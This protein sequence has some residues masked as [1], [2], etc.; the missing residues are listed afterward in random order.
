MVTLAFA[1]MA[2]YVIHDTPLGGGTDGIYLY[3]KPIIFRDLVLEGSTFIYFFTTISLFLVLGFLGL[4]SS[5]RFGRA[6]V[7]IKINELRMRAI[8]FETYWYKLVAFVISGAIAGIAGFLFAMKDGFVNP[9]I[10]SW[11]LSGTVLMMIIL[12][13]LGHLRGAV[14]GAF[15]YALLE[16][17]F[18]SETIFGSFSKNWHLGLGLTLILSVALLPKGLFGMRDQLQKSLSLYLANFK[19]PP[20]TKL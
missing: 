15:T 4:L 9:E 11:H 1:Q 19:K 12:G 20:K 14:I 5:S 8:G 18:R 6:L 7:G 3:H 16:E 10:L 2:Y 17:I 13:G